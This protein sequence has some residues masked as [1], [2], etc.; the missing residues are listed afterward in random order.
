MSAVAAIVCSP[1]RAVSAPFMDE[2]TGPSP[3]LYRSDRFT[4]RE[5][6]RRRHPEQYHA[7]SVE[8][9]RGQGEKFELGR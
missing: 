1:K 8:N 4:T 6:R 2:Q 3:H 5:S 9:V 7:L